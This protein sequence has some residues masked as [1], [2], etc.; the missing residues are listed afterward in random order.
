[1]SGNELTA[2][3]ALDYKH[4]LRIILMLHTEDMLHMTNIAERLGIKNRVG[5]ANV[6]KALENHGLI[7]IT[8]SVPQTKWLTLTDKGKEVAGRVEEIANLLL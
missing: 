3:E 7:T 2:L 4:S 5:I 8:T 1:M 6:A